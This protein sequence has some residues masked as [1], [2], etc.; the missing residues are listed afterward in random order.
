VKPELRINSILA[1][2]YLILAMASGASLVRT[3]HDAGQMRGGSLL[4]TIHQQ[5]GIPGDYAER[6]GMPLQPECLNLVDVGLDHFGRPVRLDAATAH[7]WLLMQQAATNAGQTLV[8]ISG[9]RS[10][11]YQAELFQRKLAKGQLLVEILRVNAA[12]GFSE[13]HSGRALDLGSPGAPVLE[14]EFEHSS[15]FAWLQQH[16]QAF[17]FRM[18][19]PRNNPYGVLYEPWHW[20]YHGLATDL[21][22]GEK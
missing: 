3:W 8:L 1:I 11:T 7:A 19:F 13:H 10:Y 12:P 4:P 21:A 2:L 22:K 20:Y 14:E 16:A 17:G 5:L 18:S 6:C 9:F 15:A